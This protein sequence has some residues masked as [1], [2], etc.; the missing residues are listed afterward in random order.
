M[1][2]DAHHGCEGVLA[3]LLEKWVLLGKV[4]LCLGESLL[5]LTGS[6]WQLKMYLFHHEKQWW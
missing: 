2:P 4:P 5:K 3:R 1:G 6:K